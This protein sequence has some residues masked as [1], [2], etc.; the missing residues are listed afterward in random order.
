MS[1]T[2]LIGVGLVSQKTWPNGRYKAFTTAKC[3]CLL[4]RFCIF[5]WEIDTF[6][7]RRGETKRE[8][9]TYKFVQRN[10]QN[11]KKKIEW[12][13]IVCLFFVAI[14]TQTPCPKLIAYAYCSAH[15]IA[16]KRD[17]L[18]PR[19]CFSMSNQAKERKKRTEGKGE[20]GKACL[21]I[22]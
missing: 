16:S 3:C 17:C 12:Y 14:L 1:R 6:N 8:S 2:R 9:M 22:S 5:G 18:C 13:L 11:I 4:R 20:W 15:C 7:W 19:P 10:T 21:L